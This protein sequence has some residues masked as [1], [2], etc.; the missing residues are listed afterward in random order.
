M[1]DIRF[2]GKAID[3][4]VWCYGYLTVDVFD[5]PFI[6]TLSGNT[7]Y[8]KKVI[9]KTIGQYLDSMDKNAVQLC[10]GDIIKNNDIIWLLYYDAMDCVHRMA[11]NGIKTKNDHL[12]FGP[13]GQ[14]SEI[15]GNIHENPELLNPQPVPAQTAM[16]A[17]EKDLHL[18]HN[19]DLDAAKKL[20]EDMAD[21][22]FKQAL[23]DKNK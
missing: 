11:E 6:D 3:S 18:L 8:S 2:R 15:I 7:L 5:V 23:K 16:S 19:G 10:D 22:D 20:A 1:R 21:R 9:A 17:L 12:F 4:D 13:E 14:F